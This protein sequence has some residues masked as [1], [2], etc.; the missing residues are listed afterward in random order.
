[1]SSISLRVEAEEQY[2]RAINKSAQK[3]IDLKS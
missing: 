2:E 3:I 1:M